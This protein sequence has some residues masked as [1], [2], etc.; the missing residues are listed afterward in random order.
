VWYDRR[1]FAEA[2]VEN[3]SQM[4]GGVV[5][6]SSGER[7]RAIRRCPLPLLSRVPPNYPA[8][9]LLYFPHSFRWLLPLLTIFAVVDS[10]VVM[11]CGS[12][13]RCLEI[14]EK[15][16]LRLAFG[17]EGGGGGYRVE[18][19]ILTTSGS[20]LDAREVVV[21]GVASKGRK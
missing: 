2:I 17:R 15:D 6:K 7:R 5:D 18:T 9:P 20:R 14:A 8:R 19:P 1:P 21:V 4:R 11:M 12:G 10:W 16:H 3:P 13:G